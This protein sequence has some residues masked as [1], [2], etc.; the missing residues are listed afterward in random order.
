MLINWNLWIGNAWSVKNEIE[1]LQIHV[2]KISPQKIMQAWRCRGTRKIREIKEDNVD[3]LSYLNH[4]MLHPTWPL[5]ATSELRR[6]MSANLK[7]FFH[8]DVRYFQFC[9]HVIL[10][11][12][13]VRE[14]YGLAYRLKD[15]P[16]IRVIGV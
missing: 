14:N 13:Y 2:V 12:N 16:S 6:I 15:F 8:N 11:A 3:N 5:M 1:I 7:G 4:L 9:A 10:V